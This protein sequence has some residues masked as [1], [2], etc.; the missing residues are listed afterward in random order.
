MVGK[1]LKLEWPITLSHRVDEMVEKHASALA[2]KDESGVELTYLQMARR[3]NAISKSLA[4]AGIVDGE[5][6]GVFQEP[7]A[8]FVCSMLAIFRVGAV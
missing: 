2:I 3:V 5:R 8:D 4:E 7:S 1:S 6:V